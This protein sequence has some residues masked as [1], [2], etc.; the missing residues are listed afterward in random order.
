VLAHHYQN[1]TNLPGITG[2]IAVLGDDLIDLDQNHNIAWVW[3]AFDHLCPSN[4]TSP[5]LDINRQPMN[6]PDWLHSNALV[7]SQDDGNIVMSIRNQSWIVKIDYEDGQGTGDILWRLGYQGDFTLTNG[8]IP[9]WF[10]AQHY[11]NIISPNS[12]G[13]F[14]LELFDDGDNRVLDAAGDVCGVPG[15]PA[16]WSR[17]P[18]Y[19]IDESAMTATIAW[20]DNL[21]PVFAFWGGSAQQLPN[22]NVV[23]CITTPSDDPAD[24]RYMEVTDDPSPQVVLKMEVTG[25]NA[26]RGV[27]MP[28]LYPGVQW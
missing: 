13:V 26:Y 9:D 6:F 7:Y 4:P 10:S 24:G 8:Q 16:C 2:T 1:F 18:I 23:F 21:S 19:Q 22:S 20:D 28:S 17:V 25:Q 12:T 5:C 27:H 15:Q 11:A 3:N 14:N